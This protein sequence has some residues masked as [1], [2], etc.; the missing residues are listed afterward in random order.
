MTLSIDDVRHVANLARLAFDDD[1]LEQLREELG[2]ILGYAEQIDE[3]AT[4]D[5][6]PTSHAYRL[7][8]VWRDDDVRPSLEPAAALSTGPA[9][10]DGRFRV[11]RIIDEDA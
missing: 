2:R 4:T 5:V 1:Q 11:P 8:N 9:I 3:V 10:E 6:P 7:T